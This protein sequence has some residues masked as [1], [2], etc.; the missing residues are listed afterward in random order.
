MM[1]TQA[2]I[3]FKPIKSKFP[4]SIMDSDGLPCVLSSLEDA[5]RTIPWLEED[6]LKLQ[7][8][9]E[10]GF[11]VSVDTYHLPMLALSLEQLEKLTALTREVEGLFRSWQETPTGKAWVGKQSR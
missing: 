2:E 1:P 10:D 4:R 9:L 6:K 5:D 11:R 8:D 7:F 3:D